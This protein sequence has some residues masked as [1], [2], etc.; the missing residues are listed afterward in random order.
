MNSDRPVVSVIVPVYK[1]ERYLSACIDS[2]R[3]Q[4]LHDIEI[5][6]VDDGS[7]DR[8]PQMCDEYA[9]KDHRIVVIHKHNEGPGIARN[10]GVLKSRGKWVCFVDSDDFIA[11]NTLEECVSIGERSATD[12]VR[13]LL[14]TVPYTYDTPSTVATVVDPCGILCKTFDEKV[15]PMLEAITNIPFETQAKSSDSACTALFRRE[16][17]VK[18]DLAFRSD[19]EIIVEDY[20][21][22]LEV[23]P[24]C[25]SIVYTANQFYFYRDTPCSRSKYRPDRMERSAEISEYLERHLPKYGYKNVSLIST[26]VMLGYLRVFLREIY[27]SKMSGAEKRKAHKEAVSHPYIQKIAEGVDY[28]RLTKIQRLAFYF[29]K[30]YFISRVL[31]GGRDF[32]RNLFGV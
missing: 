5:I 16:M 19:D 30:S 18:N 9:D 21:F 27:A 6:L 24:K 8:C 7:P 22:I 23:A 10:T 15:N 12:Q 32:V 4:T 14:G 11:L 17:L 3:R 13:F 1:A 26:A 2:L 20:A 28:K 25:S 31:L 29:R